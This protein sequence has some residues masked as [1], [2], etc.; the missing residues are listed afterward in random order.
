VPTF[1]SAQLLAALLAS[2]Q[3]HMLEHEVVVVDNGS[4]DGTV[5]LLRDRLP[6]ARLV[7]LPANMGYGRAVNRG[8]EASEADTL[9]VVNNDVACRPP[10]LKKLALPSIP[11]RESR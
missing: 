2:L 7:R 1:N 6:S 10:F 9:V 8:L 5:A 4:T 11:R 3:R